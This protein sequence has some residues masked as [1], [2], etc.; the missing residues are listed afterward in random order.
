MSKYN[1]LM[2]RVAVTP[3]MK[4]RFM[5]RVASGELAKSRLPRFR[6]IGRYAALAAC[7]VL[8]V[9]GA[10]LLSRYLPERNTAET[11]TDLAYGPIAPAE[12]KNAEELSEASGIRIHD[13]AYL[14]FEAKETVYRTFGTDF[15]EIVYTGEK[16]VVCY[17]VST[18]GG[19]TSGDYTEYPEVETRVIKGIDVILKGEGGLVHCA[20]YEKDGCSFSITSESGLTFD[21]IERML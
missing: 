13:L 20:L 1:D 4:E 10:A 19:D 18:G 8:L 15:A 7:L 3:E 21:E 12:Y 9:A 11:E 14:P 2:E 5:N 16:D 6:M 17:R